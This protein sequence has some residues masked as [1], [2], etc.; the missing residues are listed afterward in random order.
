MNIMI[1]E[2]Y[3]GKGIDSIGFYKSDWNNYFVTNCIDLMDEDSIVIAEGDKANDLLYKAKG[4]NGKYIRRLFPNEKKKKIPI[5]KESLLFIK[6]TGYEYM[7]N[8]FN[9]I[10]IEEFRFYLRCMEKLF[11]IECQELKPKIILIL[12]TYV[13]IK[14]RELYNKLNIKTQR[15]EMYA[16][17]QYDQFLDSEYERKYGHETKEEREKRLK[18]LERCNLSCK[19]C[20]CTYVRM[21]VNEVAD[22]EK[23][24]VCPKCKGKLEVK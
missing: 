21:K 10:T 22:F 8:H 6:K 17:E 24:L 16:Y 11:Q 13:D 9:E 18:E 15:L 3:I 23:T 1:K 20:N 7:Q 4:E 19:H 5:S 12:K 2:V 14:I